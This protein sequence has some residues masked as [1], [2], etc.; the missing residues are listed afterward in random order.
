MA[1]AGVGAFVGSSSYV[2]GHLCFQE[3]L[4]HP[5]DDLVQEV[6]VI[7]QDPLRHLCIQLA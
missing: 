7:Q 5:L 4:E 6:W 3:L 1:L 2:L